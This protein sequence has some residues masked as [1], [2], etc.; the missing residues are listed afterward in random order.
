VMKKES[1]SQIG[2]AGNADAQP[3]PARSRPVVLRRA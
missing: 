2:Q 3:R 1:R